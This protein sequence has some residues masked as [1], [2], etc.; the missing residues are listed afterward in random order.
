MRR[1]ADGSFRY[2]PTDLIAFLEGDFAAWCERNRAEHHSGGRGREA[3]GGHVLAP[4][5]Q[6]EELELV[7]RRGLAHEAEQ[8]AR[9]KTREPALV[10]IPRD[11]MALDRTRA[12]MQSGAP[13]IFQGELRAEPWMGIADFLHRVD[14]PSTL[15]RHHY[16]PWDTKL[17]RS[18]K[19]YFLLQLAAYAEMLEGMQ[20]RRPER[21]GFVL[22]DGNEVTFR[23]ADVWHYYR[24][25]KRSFE[26]FQARWTVDDLPDPALDRTHGRW[27]ESAAA[28]LEHVDDLS[29][30]AGISRS[31]IVRLR[32][33]GIDTVAQLAHLD[34]A[35]AGLR[36][37]AA[38]L[39]TL[40][41]QAA[42]QVATRTSGTIAWKLRPV[43]TEGPPRGL[44]LLPPP[45]PLDVFLDL[46]GFPYAEG[47][48]E[49]LIGATTIADDGALAFDD[50]WAHDSAAERAAFEGFMDWAWQR[51]KQDPAMHIYHYAAYE[52]TAFSR[53]SIK[54]ATREYELDQLL[55]HDV[56][57]DLYTVVRQGMVIGTPSY[58]LKEIE[59]LYMPPRSGDVTSA[60]GSVVEYQRWLDSGEAGAWTESPILSAIRDYNRVDCESMV[61]LRDWLLERQREADVTWTPRADL[62]QTAISDRE[63]SEVERYAAELLARALVLPAD[64][65]QRRITE[66]LAWLLEYHRRDAKP[67]W[68]RY[69]ERLKMS[70]DDLYADADCLAGVVRT[71]TAPWADKRS[72]VYEYTFDPDQDTR[73]HEGSAVHVRGD[74]LIPT[75]IHTMDLAAGRLTLKLGVG[76][77]VPD[78]CQLIPNEY[79][80]PD[81][82]PESVERYVRSWDEGTPSSRAV[83]DL[84][85]RHPPRMR[86]G[87]GL[88][89]E[90]GG[91]SAIDAA[92][93]MDGTTLAIQ[94]PPGTG[95]TTTGARIIA[96]LLADGK[97]V[98]VMATGHAVILNLLEKLAEQEPGLAGRVFKVG[99]ESD[100][101]LVQ[102][103]WMQLRESAAAAGV[104]AGQPCVIGGTA[105]L[106]SRPEMIGTLD[107]LFID[108]AGQVPLANAVAA[109]MAAKNLILMG[110]QMQLAQPTQGDHPGESGASCLAYLLQ[111]H[112]VIPDSLGIFLGTSFRMHPD[113]CSLISDCF[114]EGR[115]SSH[116]ATTGNR[117][118]VK[119]PDAVASGSGV[120][121]LP[122]PHDGNTQGS[123]EEVEQIAELVDS[124][125]QGTVT[126]RGGTPR[127]L[128]LADILIVAP[129]NLQ[130][131]ALRGRLGSEARIGS[132][133]KFQGQ[134]APVV[135]VS[136][137]ASTLDDAPRGP[138]FLLSP[139]RLNVAIS[140]AQALAIVVGSPLLGDVRVRSVEEL[141][142]VS[143]WCRIESA[144][145]QS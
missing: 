68:W 42:M 6:D 32:D 58:S 50:W 16:E 3:L 109:G 76:R 113:V 78:R 99:K 47:G 91:T 30:I 64:S 63:P 75:T 11:D 131:R 21:F 110:D 128:T 118:N 119:S 41:D 126:I 136:M 5:D 86:D 116:A 79:V 72:L 33:A 9:L 57:V 53:L 140:R 59:H 43:P 95:K 89:V 98:G 85:A 62:P 39:A 56:F 51:L 121:F 122:V 71:A 97:R 13:I 103:G 84:I 143:R 135:I 29:L 82:I 107:Y 77:S 48:R 96:A 115:L 27:G 87:L 129:F 38:S 10:E 123:E 139:N 101:P 61:P 45:S 108:E 144:G 145:A 26:D 49:Y 132:V 46:E 92:R 133:D 40:R 19:P 7:A 124:L 130:V 54:Y 18:P 93:A 117:V 35:P 105:W 70:E 141:Q 120:V 12:A 111:G 66:L 88:V 69:F 142:L 23:T 74:T 24:R 81:P 15:G 106:F 90:G 37:T 114:Y 34:A 83:A 112:S 44:A 80:K 52:R 14:A 134:E 4:D 100:H 55:R 28:L 36:M 60:G 67:M 8:L 104:L 25:L 20:G 1:L 125:V 2:S 17:A 65:E 137:C 127:A 94:G 138:Q 31:Q 73:L 22:G 102:S